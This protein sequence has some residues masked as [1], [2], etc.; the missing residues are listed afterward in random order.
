MVLHSHVTRREKNSFR[1]VEV[2][3]HL[4]RNLSPNISIQTS[5]V[6]TTADLTA[7]KLEEVVLTGWGKHEIEKEEE[8][9]NGTG[10]ALVLVQAWALERKCL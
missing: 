5:I 7:Q 8:T 6:L 2:N 1:Y 3:P 4:V 9:R 10:H